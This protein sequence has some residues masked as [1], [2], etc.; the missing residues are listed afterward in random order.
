MTAAALHPAAQPA[1]PLDESTI[2][3]RLAAE[4][5]TARLERDR[6]IAD[7]ENLDQAVMSY[8][9]NWRRRT[10]PQSTGDIHTNG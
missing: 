2:V 10:Q 8:R 7:A 1:E 4:L 9:D 6:A 3:A 5:A